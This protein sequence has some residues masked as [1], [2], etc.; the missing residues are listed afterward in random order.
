MK[1]FLKNFSKKIGQGLSWMA[2]PGG[3]VAQVRPK[4]FLEEFLE[5]KNQK[6]RIKNFLKKYI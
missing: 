4:N 1:A 2:R 5:Q 6:K 3:R